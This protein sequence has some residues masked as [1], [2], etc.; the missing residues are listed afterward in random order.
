MFDGYRFRAWHGVEMARGNDIVDID[1]L[2][3]GPWTPVL[4]GQDQG[5][6]LERTQLLA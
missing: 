5:G 2:A 1:P 6:G 3:H 4:R